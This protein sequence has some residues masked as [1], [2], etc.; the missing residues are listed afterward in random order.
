MSE[1]AGIDKFP[2]VK[3]FLFTAMQQEMENLF[4]SGG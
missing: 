1:G 2:R 4:S 3:Y